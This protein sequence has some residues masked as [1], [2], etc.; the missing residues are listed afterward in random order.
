VWDT[1][2][3]SL[4]SP[5][6]GLGVSSF[7]SRSVFTVWSGEVRVVDEI[8]MS[9]LDDWMEAGVVGEILNVLDLTVGTR[10]TVDAGD[11]LE[12]DFVGVFV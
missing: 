4:Q 7:I 11:V 1:S 5:L 9:D 3:L 12:L 2:C 8:W 10:V 6:E